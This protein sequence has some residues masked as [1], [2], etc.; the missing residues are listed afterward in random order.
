MLLYLFPCHN[1]HRG[2]RYS[3]ASAAWVLV[4][5]ILIFF[6]KAGF[7]LVEAA[8]VSDRADRRSVILFKYLDTCASA[9]AY[10]ILG[11]GISQGNGPDLND[12][13][14]TVQFFF[15]FTFASNTATI[16]GGALCGQPRKMRLVAIPIYAF[17]ISGIIHPMVARWVWAI[18]SDK[19]P[20][21]FRSGWLSPYQRRYC[22]NESAYRQL[23]ETGLHLNNMYVLDFAGGGAVHLL[24]GVAGLMLL[25]VLKL[26]NY[27]RNKISP[28]DPQVTANSG[29]ERPSKPNKFLD[30]M[31]PHDGGGDLFIEDSALGVFILWT[32]WS[33]SQSFYAAYLYV[34][35]IF[36]W[37]ILRFAFNCGSTES[38]ESNTKITTYHEY[39]QYAW[40]YYNVPGRIAMNM[41]I[42][43]GS[44]GLVAVCIA[45][46]A[47]LRTRGSS[48]NANEI[49]NGVLGALV[50]IT[51]GCPFVYPE[52]AF[53]I[54]GIAVLVYHFGCW[55]EYKLDLEDTA[56]VF[57]VHGMCG[58]WSMLAPG[59]YLSRDFVNQVYEGLCYCHIYL[60]EVGKGM[61]LLYQLLGIVVIATWSALTCGF[62]FLVLNFIPAQKFAILLAKCLCIYEGNNP[63]EARLVF[64]RGLL[65]TCPDE[66]TEHIYDGNELDDINVETND[67]PIRPVASKTGRRNKTETTRLLSETRSLGGQTETAAT[68]II[69]RSFEINSD[70][71]RSPYTKNTTC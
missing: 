41:I 46:A 5:S 51:S 64:K 29:Q 65:F 43:A 7:M 31:Y 62:L 27:L 32:T 58:L 59:I 17:M 13:N 22:F 63:E 33:V 21:P 69:R 39:G 14:D 2:Y 68:G 48:T 53:G 37:P 52:W 47:Q 4:A 16:I 10:W 12:Q 54:G 60:P 30:W 66:Y 61:R 18:S 45:G 50:A 11:Y 24:G 44:A 20:A 35:V 57:P 28:A 3:D 25:L 34:L 42:C 36:L 71:H 49:A 67:L 9:I 38:V 26:D 70:H 1:V 8:F 56:R 6:M 40:M 19:D 15:K 23:N 55:I